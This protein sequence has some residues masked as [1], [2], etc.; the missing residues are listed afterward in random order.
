MPAVPLWLRTRRSLYSGISLLLLP[1][2]VLFL[3][4][5]GSMVFAKAVTANINTV[6]QFSQQSRI[7]FQSGDDWEPSI[8]ADRHGHVYALYKH[9]AITGGQN[10]AGC[11]RH[12]LVQRSDDGGRTWD[13]PRPI[14]PGPVKGGQF[15]SQIVVDPVDGKTLWASFLQFSN[16]LIGVVKSTDFGQTWSQVQIV[17][18]QPP[19]LDK[20]ELAVRGNTVLVAYDDNF[21]TFASVTLDGGKH[22]QSHLV[23]PASQQLSLTL[24]AGAAIDSLGNFHISWDSYDK[25]HRKAGQ[26]PVTL[27]VSKS[28]D[29]GQTWT[30][31]II[32][33]SAGAAPICNPCGFDYLSS[34]MA[35]RIGSDDTIYLLWNSNVDGINNTPE[36][37]F[38]SRSMNY[39]RTFSL[40]ADISDASFGVEHCF[41]SIAVGRNAGDVRIGWMDTRTGAW[42][43]FFRKSNDGGIHFSGTTRIS[44]FVPG[45]PYLTQVGFS[46]PYGDYFSMAVDGQNNTQLA[47][48]EGPSYAGPGNQWVSHSSNG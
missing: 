10:C 19:G 30:R 22:W 35:L 23:F 31:T 20:D 14:A 46:L 5:H 8:A 45:Y 40:P 38:F 29:N 27:W 15:D 36:R 11:D 21:N 32:G 33:V 1:G 3:N 2:I 7:G 17:S 28:T 34:Q 47:W 25:A 18:N 43:V 9:Y 16:S 12:L 39:G 37:I 42:N 4:A 24:S 44:G 26:G 48:G 41:P 6:I 13:A